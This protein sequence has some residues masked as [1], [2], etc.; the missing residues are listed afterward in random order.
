MQKRINQLRDKLFTKI[1]MSNLV[2]NTC[3]EDPRVDRELLEFD[4]DSKVVMITSAGCNALD[5]SLDNP[6]AINCIDMNYRQNALL[7]LKKAT[8]RNGDYKHHFKIFGKGAD[9]ETN[10]LYEKKLRKMLPKYSQE[11][12]DKKVSDF[13][14]SK[15]DKKTFYF[16]GTSGSFAWLFKKYFNSNK[17]LRKIVTELINSKTPAEQASAYEKLEPKLLSKIIIWAMNQH[18]TMAM[19]GVPRAQRDLIVAKYPDG[20]AGYLK[21]NLRHVFTELPIQDNYFWRLYIMGKYSKETCPEYLKKKNYENLQSTIDKINVHTNS[22]SGF[23][24]ENPDEYTHYVLLDHQDWLANYNPEAL[25]EE[26]K[27]ILENSKPGTKILMRSAATEI[28]F[29]PKFVTERVH[30]DLEKGEE[31]HT[32]DRVGTYGST[33]IGRVTA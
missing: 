10:K 8:I 23:L 28:N 31:Y 29:F 21:N 16:R 11:Y 5:Y 2:Y 24:K 20:M 14:Q 26:W 9:N 22:F 33:Y 4:K 15:K 30:F 19:L 1:H 25:A 27:L 3:W 12:W 32:K 6:A 18:V 13:F 17:E 7:E